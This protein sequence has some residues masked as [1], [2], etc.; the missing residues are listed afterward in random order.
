MNCAQ[1]LRFGPFRFD[2]VNQWLWHGAQAVELVPKAFAVLSYLIAH[3]GRLITREE[4]LQAVWPGVYV[5][6]AVLKVRVGEIL[7]AL[8]EQVH[9]PHTIE[10]L[11][12]RGFW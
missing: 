6:D 1:Q 7:K 12:R 8:N 2:P 4:L 5:T 9:T 11:H 10:T 3:P